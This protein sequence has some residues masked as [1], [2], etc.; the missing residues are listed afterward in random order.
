MYEIWKL[1]GGH[2]TDRDSSNSDSDDGDEAG[3]EA[4]AWRMRGRGPAANAARG[5]DSGTDVESG[6]DANED[7][8]QQPVFLT[9]RLTDQHRCLQRTLVLQHLWFRK[10]KTCRLAP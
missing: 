9:T 5:T 1:I 4:L 3:M 2:G 8:E 10:A 6:D 7:E